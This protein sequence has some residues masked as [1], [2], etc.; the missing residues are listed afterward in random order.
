MTSICVDGFNLAIAKGSGI[1]TYGRNLVSAIN[2]MGIESGAL[3]GTQSPVSRDRLLDTIALTDAQIPR[4]KPD[5]LQRWARTV[6]TRF[7]RVARPVTPAPEIIWTDA[8]G[9]Q[10]PVDKM[11]AAEKLYDYAIRGQRAYGNFT[12]LRFQGGHGPDAVHWTCPLPLHASGRTNLYTFHDLIPLKLPHSTAEDKPAYMAMCR[13]VVRKA[14]HLLAVSETTRRDVIELLGVS[15]DRI[16]TTYQSVD[17]PPVVL[18]ENEESSANYIE[19]V[20]DLGWKDYFLY[21]GAIE[22]KKNVGRIVEAY[23]ASGVKTPL[24]I[25]GGRS[26]LDKG[27]ASIISSVVESENAR[28][29]GRIRKYEFLSSDMLFRLIRGAKA[30]LF[31]SLYEGFG[32]PV[33]ESMM[34]GTAV[35]TSTA[36]SL[37]EIA[38][39][40][41]TL[42]DPYDVEAI[43]KAVVA[44]DNDAD[45][46]GSLVSQGRERA[47]AF[48]AEKHRERLHEVYSGQ[49]L[50]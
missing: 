22:P 16:T 27:E 46:V 45:L 37:P 21:Y 17:L 18:E 5:K 7:G 43:T 4:G 42:V 15:E 34:L 20:F 28:R 3:Y 14:D 40:A 30:T 39:G 35:L 13:E 36:G 23:L 47:K 44:L 50:I 32:L 11:W 33:L 1:A 41:A 6:G 25:V 2:E 10:P 19:G 48:T 26:W 9:G 49:G 12:P 31:P 38:G 29:R 24:I 8:G